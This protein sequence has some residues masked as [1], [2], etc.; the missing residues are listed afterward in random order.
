MFSVT[1][2]GGQ[3]RIKGK[4]NGEKNRELLDENLLQNAQDLR[5]G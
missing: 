3:V 5:Q 2:T 4:M 1:A